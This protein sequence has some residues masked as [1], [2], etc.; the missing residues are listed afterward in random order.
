MDEVA[1]QGAVEHTTPEPP[2]TGRY[3]DRTGVET[4]SGATV[5]PQDLGIGT[6]FGSVRDAVIVAE[7]GTGRIVLWNPAATEIF[8]YSTEE[9]L[10]L[11]VEEIV[12]ERLKERHRAGLSR[13][14]D[15]GHGSYIDSHH[16]VLDLPA[17]RKGGEEIRVELSLSP[18]EPLP[19]AG[20]EGRFVLAII[21]DVT[22]RK[23]KEKEIERLREDLE[24]RVTERTAQL[25]AALARLRKGE[26]ARS[27][28]LG[29]EQVARAEADE[30]RARLTF[31]A[32]ASEVLASSLDYRATLSNVA[33]QAVPRL[34]DWCAVDVADEEDGSLNRLAVVHEDPEKV[35]RALELQERY[36]PDPNSPRGAP[37]VLRTGR[38]ELY[39]EITDEM[40]EAAAR[41]EEHLRLLRRMGFTSVIVVP[42]VTRGKTLGVISLVSSESGRRYGEADLDLAEELARRAATAVDNARLYDVARKEV[43]ERERAEEQIRRQADLL[44]L[45]HEP[46]FAWDPEGGIAYWNRGSEELYGFSKEE[47]LGRLS[48]ELLRTVHPVPLAEFEA[49]LEREGQWLGELEHTTRDGLRVTVESRQM[50]VETSDG[51]RQVLETNRDISERKALEHELTHQAL[52]DGLTGLPNRVLFLDRLDHAL[53]RLGRSDSSVAVLFLDLDDFKIVNDSLGHEA[54]DNLLVAVS[55]RL[56]DCLREDDTLARLGGDEFTVLLEEIPDA[57]EASLI[58][59][60]VMQTFTLPFDVAGREVFVSCSVGVSLSDS[61]Q[62]QPQE[63]LR[64]A[65]VAMYRAKAGGKGRRAL[66]EPGMGTRAR[67]RLELE[68]ALRRALAQGELRVHYQPKVRLGSDRIAGMEALVR[69]EH[70]ER[71]LIPP[72]EFVPLSEETGLILPVGRWVLEEACRQA[73]EW[74]KRYPTD[75]PLPISVNLSVRQFRHQGL[76]EDVAEA[77]RK[78]GLEPSCLELEVTESAVMDDVEAAIATMGELKGLGVGLSIDDFGTGHSSLNYLRRF[79]VDELKIDKSF[80]DGLGKEAKGT[81]IMRT[82]TMLARALGLTVVAE[83]V[84]DAE[85]LACLREMECDL[86]QGYYFAR[87]MPSDEAGKLLEQNV[88]G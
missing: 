71:G 88:A 38:P 81:A 3:G 54:G 37:K 15:T 14:R 18:I 51:S 82:M 83:G 17:V 6:L 56:R 72:S 63:L 40:L 77:L 86:A 11:S 43:A 69:W 79:P 75:P 70:P 74:Q 84:E 62:S 12:P 59:E 32:E 49:M 2:R 33:R 68:S 65:D 52:H 55:G 28:L 36:P 50:L 45:S 25:E 80:V 9:A 57:S 53:A 87:P 10:G 23:R 44:D 61:A 16:A 85:Q 41:D 35:A 58:A 20:A 78:A 76:V 67:A 8:G 66:Y 42:M 39:P 24:E 48:H 19:E 31:L 29:Q 7:A 64:D 27:R 73:K 30:A 1:D 4:T 5:L 60:R 34:A 21:R 22:E 47:A 26:E 13:Y 46:I